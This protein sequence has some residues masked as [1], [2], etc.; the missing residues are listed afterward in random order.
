MLNLKKRYIKTFKDIHLDKAVVKISDEDNMSVDYFLFLEIEERVNN[1]LINS[2]IYIS[3]YP[4]EEGL[5]SERGIIK[6][7][8]KYEFAHLANAE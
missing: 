5:K 4:K 3:Q 1:Y 2:Q 6:E 7:I 8:T